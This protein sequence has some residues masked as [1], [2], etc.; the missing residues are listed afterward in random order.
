MKK[1]KALKPGEIRV[2]KIREEAIKELIVE[3]VTEHGETMFDLP[4]EDYETIFHTCFS[5]SDNTITIIAN[6]I[7]DNSKIDSGRII[8]EEKCT[9]DS[10]YR[11]SPHDN[12]PYV[13]RKL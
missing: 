2:I 4:K 3:F 5:P 7:A 10:V 12:P 11:A 1:G 8:D 6:R 13:T 9:T